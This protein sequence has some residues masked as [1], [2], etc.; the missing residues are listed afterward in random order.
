MSN[1]NSRLGRNSPAA[2]GSSAPVLLPVLRR[3]PCRRGE[4]RHP[5]Q[6]FHYLPRRKDIGHPWRVVCCGEL[7]PTQKLE[8]EHRTMSEESPNL[9]LEQLTERTAEQI[10]FMIG[11]APSDPKAVIMDLLRRYLD[12][13][14][15][16]EYQEALREQR[17]AERDQ[18]C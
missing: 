4:A 15:E 17:Q 14:R 12:H 2:L 8:S 16:H 3:E 11:A 10:I 9:D 1:G 5:H 6:C 18:L 7:E 13:V